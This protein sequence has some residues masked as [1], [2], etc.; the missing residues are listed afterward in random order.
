[1]SKL[2]QTSLEIEIKFYQKPLRNKTEREGAAQV[3]EM[4]EPARKQSRPILASELYQR[5]IV[6]QDR[7]KEIPQELVRLLE[8]QK[9]QVATKSDSIVERYQPKKVDFV[10]DVAS[11]SQASIAS[12]E[13]V[14][15]PVDGVANQM[16]ATSVDRLYAQRSIQHVR[17]RYL[18]DDSIS[19]EE[20]VTPRLSDQSQL[21]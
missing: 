9:D 20:Q 3:N 17:E 16:P 5:Q 18:D 13:L 11:E 14:D 19:D 7:Q 2:R 12:F 1:M 8:E 4:R 6:D 10:D 15:E 21:K